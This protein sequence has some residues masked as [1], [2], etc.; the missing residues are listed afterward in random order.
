MFPDCAGRPQGGHRTG[1][2]HDV[3]GDAPPR[4][5]TAHEHPQQVLYGFIG[6]ALSAQVMFLLISYDP[7][8]FRPAKLF[9]VPEKLAFAIS[10][11]HAFCVTSCFW[12][13]RRVWQHRIAWAALFATAW[14]ITGRAARDVSLQLFNNDVKQTCGERIGDLPLQKPIARDLDFSLSEFAFCHHAVPSVC[15]KFRLGHLEHVLVGPARPR[16]NPLPREGAGRVANTL[17]R[18]ASLD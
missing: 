13:F 15:E 7:L 3:L 1:V 10:G 18:G 4:R 14:V 12:P 9:G 17:L 2:S 8:R 5:P 16:L 11:V 6:T